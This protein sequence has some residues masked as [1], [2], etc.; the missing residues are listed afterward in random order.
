MESVNE[1]TK[2][3]NNNSEDEF[4]KLIN[5]SG[6]NFHFEI[7]ELLRNEGWE[8]E[9]SPYY[10]D[11]TM[12]KPREVD[13]IASKEIGINEIAGSFYAQFKDRKELGY[14]IYLFIECKH[15]TKETVLWMDII[16]SKRAKETV[17]N[18]IVNIDL[19]GGDRIFN[20]EQIFGL[21]LENHHY[22]IVY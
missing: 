7:V 6:H 19:G 15:L 10:Y 8:T 4:Q 11:D 13:I 17:A 20:I 2:Q 16:K 18:S 14:K 1:K 12:N 9:I 5:N 3:N 22:S 21:G